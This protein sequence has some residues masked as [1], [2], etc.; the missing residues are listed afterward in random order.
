MNENEWEEVIKEE[1]LE[2][3]IPTTVKAGKKTILLI[4]SG[5]NIYANS[6]KCPHYGAPLRDG[7]LLDHHLTC[8]WH[9][10]RFDITSGK[11]ESPPALSDLTHYQVKV[12]NGAVFV[13]KAPSEKAVPAIKD[14]Q[15]V[16]ILGAGA[17]GNACAVTLRRAGFKGRVIMATSESELP[18]DRP[19]LSKDFL[20]GEV[21]KEWIPLNTEQYYRELEIEILRNHKA[22][23]VD[24]QGRRVLFAH[25]GAVKFDKLLLATGS[26]PRTPSIPGVNVPGFFLL[27]SLADA[28]SILLALNKVKKV[29]VMGAGFIGLEV[30]SALRSLDLLVNVVSPEQ[31]PMAG[32]FGERI[33]KW[34]KRIHQES[35]TRFFLSSTVN[36]IRGI[37]R[38][39][40]VVCSTGETI[41]ADM[42]I[43]GIGVVPAVAYLQGTNLTANGGVPVNS[44]LETQVSGIYAAGDIAIVPDPFTGEGR[45]IEHWVEAERQGMHVAGCIM[46]SEEE[47]KEVPFFWSKQHETMLKYIGYTR[48]YDQVS[49]HGEVESGKFL[50]G[51]YEK[52]NLRA[53]AG[54]GMDKEI[55]YI[56]NLLKNGKNLP[57]RLLKDSTKELEQILVE[58]LKE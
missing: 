32:I 27:R 22:V 14:K 4:R 29:V 15:T 50:A 53:A 43:A 31:I 23:E 11:M 54:C 48:A 30:A 49:Y 35:G 58:A 24:I 46:G 51:F 44:H 41:P 5:G 6:G 10:A 21:K 2:E 55:I 28:E 1:Q 16:L 36:E 52:G 37:G 34:I 18:Y 38:L 57:S 26:I 33:G 47:Y 7:V 9:N 19:N 3:G 39:K 12:E 42:V 20:T 13:R 8:P 56:Q 17:A 45:R 25:G 40:E